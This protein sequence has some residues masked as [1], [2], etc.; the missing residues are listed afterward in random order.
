MRKYSEVVKE[1]MVKR[2]TS[3]GGLSAVRL[4]QEVGIAHQ[5][6]SRWVKEY[7]K[8]GEM[9]KKTKGVQGWSS[10]EKLEALL[11]SSHLEGQELGEYLRRKGLHSADLECWKQETLEG[12]KSVGR[13]RPKKDPEILEL[14][15]DKKSLQRELRRKEKALAEA[16]ALLVLK[17]KAELIWGVSED[18]ESD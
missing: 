12:L 11:E 1:S 16:S 14:R 18:D 15:K 13:G 8:L 17:K 4:S 3:P 9:G 10:E 6:L 5:T 2:M 7:G